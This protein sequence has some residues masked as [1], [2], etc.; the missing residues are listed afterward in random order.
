MH[1][2]EIAIF[3]YNQGTFLKNCIESIE[4]N[5][6]NI[7]V[8]VYDDGSNEPETVRYLASISHIVIFNPKNTYERHGGYYANM[9]IAFENSSSDFLLLIQDDMQIV[10]PV[11]SSDLI[12]IDRIFTRFKEAAFLSPV[13]LKG[14]KRKF[15]NSRYLT[16]PSTHTC[17][18][19]DD[20]DNVI[21]SCYADVS[22]VNI[23]RLRE[24]GWG[25]LPSE[26][27]NGRAAK[28]KF[29]RMPQMSNPFTFY[30]P[31]EPAY[32]GRVMM[33][34]AKLAFKMGGEKIKNFLDMSG[35][36]TEEFL[37][38]DK[39]IFLLQRTLY[40]LPTPELKSL[41]SLMAIERTLL[42]CF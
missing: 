32:R 17:V 21:P 40:K 29:G 9:Q 18:W 6:P 11:N 36:E 7:P 27:E 26:V 38:R 22:I 14:R 25:F 39:R 20:L 10:K 41:I 19:S 1:S 37:N 3:T 28:A 12:D 24:T 13:F 15:F 33:I 5:L 35:S 34:G 4:R 2:L 16:D 8:A 30:L 23:K 42:Q 31:E